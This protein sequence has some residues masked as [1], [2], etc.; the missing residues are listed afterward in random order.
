M[1]S[2]PRAFVLAV[3]ALAMPALMYATPAGAQTK[4]KMVL[5]WKYQGPQGWFFLADDRGYLKAK[6]LEVTMDQGNGSGAAV[7]LV[8]NGTY[9]TRARARS[10]PRRAARTGRNRRGPWTRRVR[11]WRRA[12]RRFPLAAVDRG[13]AGGL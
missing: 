11:A 10:C 8:A 5:N 6:G 2:M 1:K 12:P 3:F 7:P 13:H 9:D 4:L